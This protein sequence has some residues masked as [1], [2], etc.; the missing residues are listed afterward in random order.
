MKSKKILCIGDS[1]ALPGHLNKYEDTWFYKLK[2]EFPDFDFISFFKRQLTTDALTSMGGG[3]GGV[4]NWPKGA[5][6]L[7]G[8]MPDVVI[9][10]LGIVDCA[11]RLLSNYDRVII[12]ILPKVFKSTYIKL[13][14]LIKKRNVNNTLVPYEKFKKNVLN[15]VN[16]AKNLGTNII[17]ISISIPDSKMVIKNKDIVF[18]V[19]RYNEYYY[20]MANDYSFVNTTSAL[21]ANDCDEEVYED[22]Y[23]PNI[24]GNDIIYNKL[25]IALNELS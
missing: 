19:N 3:I 15:Y 7:E 4:D 1:L 13:I 2:Q 25:K 10:Q 16:R 12:K 20:K 8:Y 17:F 14:K 22:G 21:N 5:D 9:I 11:P 18:N 6:C 23:H 24:L